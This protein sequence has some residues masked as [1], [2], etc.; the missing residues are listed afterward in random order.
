MV[1][2][3]IRVLIVDD[4]ALVRS[5]LSKGLSQDPSIEVVGVA[6]DVYVARDKI[7]L[8]KPHVVTLD[9]EMPRMDGVEFLKRLMPQYPIPVVMVSAMTAPGARVTLDALENGAVDFV[10]KPSSSF[11]NN[12]EDMLGELI[13]KI[14]A[15]S[16]V[17][18]SRFKG[19]FHAKRL[20]KQVSGVLSGSTDKVVAI[21]AS[22]G[23]TV[24]L[25]QIVEAFPSDMPGTVIVQHMPPKFTKMFADKLNE[26]TDVEVKEAENGDRVL[27]GRVLVAPGGYH[28]EIVRSGGRYIVRIKEGDKVNGHCPSVDVLFDS[29]AEHVGPNAVGA[30]LT[31]MGRDGA[32]GLLRMKNNGA[33][34][35]AQDEKSSVVFGMPKEAWENGGAEKLVSLEE[36]PKT[37]VSILKELDR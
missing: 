22:T 30:L 1:Q 13:E 36:I 18:V 35:I 26:I 27:R 29:V 33:R 21:G 17:D 4:S 28:M 31:G 11:G 15:A 9:V 20:R 6:P 5:I 16:V 24:A 32:D 37:L 23:G 10:L 19:R 25:R 14:K 2:H 8:L 7:V 3:K 12:L 34:T